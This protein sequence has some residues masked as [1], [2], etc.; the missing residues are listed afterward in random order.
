MEKS[1]LFK[2]ATTGDKTLLLLVLV[3]AGLAG[4]ALRFPLFPNA[5][6]L[7]GSL[8]A[9]IA[10]QLLGLG[11]G[12]LAAALISSY[13]IFLWNQP[14][15]LLILTIETGAAGWL[16]RRSKRGMVIAD[17]IY[18]LLIGMPLV[19]LF[20]HTVMHV[21][22]SNTYI[23][24]IKQ[25]VNGIANA[26]AA[27]LLFTGFSMRSRSALVS[28]SE[29][30][31]NL[32]AFFILFPALTILVINCKSDYRETDHQIRTLLIK[33]IQVTDEYL[34]NWA[35]FQKSSI[36][37]LADL[38]SSRPLIE[39]Q[40]YLELASK[41][42]PDLL[43]VSL[44][45]RDSAL[46]VCYPMLYKE[47]R[48][49]IG[50]RVP[51][52]PFVA[53]LKKT[54]TPMLTEVVTGRFGIEHP[55]VLMVA[56]MVV[57]GEYAGYVSGILSLESIQAFLNRRAHENEMLYTLVDQN[58]NVIM[59]NRSDQKA[60]EPFMRGKGTLKQ[61]DSSTKQWIPAAPSNVS[62]IESWRHSFYVAE[63]VIGSLGEWKLIMEQ[64]VDP[65]QI[66]LYDKYARRLTFLFLLL[67][68]GLILAEVLSRKSVATL[69]N[70]RLLTRDLP[71]RLEREGTEIAWP[72]SSIREMHHLVYNFK[73][74]A[75][76]LKARFDD[77]RQ[78]NQSLEVRV[79][80]QTAE[81]RESEERY[82]SIL[83]ASPDNVTITDM[84][85]RILMISPVGLTMS[86]FA[87]EE[88]VVGRLITDFVV[89]E[90]R[91][92]ALSSFTLKS[93]GAPSGLTEYRVLRA[94]GS[95]INIEVK[96]DTIQGAEG[97][98]V[99]MIFIIRDIT[100]RKRAEEERKKLQAQLQQSQKMEAIGTLAGGIAHD[101][102]NILG[103]I[104]GYTE[105]AR[106]DCISGSVKSG[107]L[108]QVILAVRRARDLVK[109]IL[110]FSRKTETRKIPLQPAVIVKESIKLL[111]SSIPT[112]IDIRQDIDSVTDLILADPTQIHQ[113]ILNLSTNAYHAME[114]T[115]G[116][117]LISLKNLRNGHRDPLSGAHFK[118][119]HFVQLSIRDT[120]AGIAPEIMERIF[121]PYFTTK[122]TG[123]GTGMGLAIVHGI[124]KSCGGSISCKSEIGA[125]TVFELNFPA[126]SEQIAPAAEEVQIIPVGT[127][128][129]L[130]VDDE[131][132]LVRMGKTLL[133]R[134]GYTV[135]AL[136]SSI[137]ALTA[138]KNQPDSFDLV[139]TDQTMPGMT[140]IDLARE[141]LRMKPDLPIILCT[142]YS[143]QVSE[144][145]AT[146]HGIRGFSLKPLAMKN[147]A[148]L[149]RKMLNGEEASPDRQNFDEP[150]HQ[151]MPA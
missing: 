77:I 2:R 30:L 75:N 92:R 22:P 63:T 26:I 43:R 139:I 14:F 76:S 147:I 87:R 55:S 35:A 95:I 142:G 4:N 21:S 57:H 58:G 61:F 106:E 16:M 113:I 130:L 12:I 9:L 124:V 101:F 39:M 84:K 110:A 89:P 88:E 148:V 79:R 81:L 5:D 127:E 117:L 70:L 8:F 36:D 107:D 37:S 97:Q 23:I 132:T 13:T 86:G 71:A 3:A 19:Y 6:F 118:P 42:N 98:P 125:G 54:L 99:R 120:G 65:F 38:A 34:D 126:L 32:L 151:V 105:M 96:S 129:I 94:E 144:A 29:I 140:G 73:E 150:T 135:T 69:V 146:A 24:M 15:S 47:D 41:S 133:E 111:R 138:F 10:L 59:T 91:E 131:E 115:G 121:D 128:R 80:E 123:K 53:T 60:M 28:S 83:K 40:P 31:Y 20:S 27:R 18:W 104:L 134:L 7:F 64:P 74:M 93:R 49:N 114:E 122:E 66:A 17:M 45:D 116:T 51:D 78:I 48:D 85:G 145:T 141:I 46:T 56:P 102:N 44:H 62:S 72:A 149:I 119:E 100:K 108:D 109:Q 103:A 50:K 52:N 1:Q 33:D 136:T 143:S 11:W 82:R 68:G 137:K 90:D 25:A 112:T 67:L